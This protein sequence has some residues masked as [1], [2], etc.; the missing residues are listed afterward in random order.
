MD[1]EFLDPTQDN[2]PQDG[3]EAQVEGNDYGDN[4]QDL[5]EEL[6]TALKDL[7]KQFGGEDKSVRRTEVQEAR[8]QRFYWRGDQYIYWNNTS[9]MF[10]PLASEGDSTD[11]PAYQDVYNIY[12][13]FGRGIISVLS[14]NAPGV[15]FEPDDP[16]N[17]ADITTANAAE[18]FR[19]I[20]DR[21][22]K[23]KT[24][25]AEISRL[26]WTDG[27]VVLYTRTVTDAQQFGVDVQGNPKSEEVITA[28][29]V[30]ESKVPCLTKNQTEWPYVILSDEIDINIAK[31]TYKNAADEIKEGSATTGESAYE[32]IARMGVLQG[33]KLLMQAGDAFGHMVTRQRVYLRP[34]AFQKVGNETTRQQLEQLYPE[35]CFIIFCGDAYCESR[36]ESM[37][38]HI[39]V[40]H[41]SPGDG[42]NRSSLGKPMV[43]IQDAFNDLMNE[44]REVYDYCIPVT[45][46]NAE[47]GDI[48]ALREQISEPGNHIPVSA[49]SGLTDLQGAFYTEP[50]ASV[51]GDMVEAINFLGGQL[52]QNITGALPALMGEQME[53]NDTAAAYAQAKNQAMGQLSLAWGSLQEM[54]AA[55]YKQAVVCAASKRSPDQVLFANIPNQKGKVT[56]ES[57]A[58]A[59]LQKGNFHAFPDTESS[60]PDTFE[61]KRATY[62][63]LMAAGDKNQ[64]LQSILTQPDNLEMAQQ[65]IGL[66]DLVIPGADA[67]NKQLKEI[68]MLLQQSPVP[69]SQ[70]ETMQWQQMAQQAQQ[71]GQQPPPQPQP[72]PSIQI[73]AQFDFHEYEYQEVQ[74]WL[75]T[76]EAAMAKKI[77]PQ[78]IQN[79]RLH[80]LA[81]FQQVQ[82]LQQ[83]QQAQQNPPNK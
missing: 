79:V 50:P 47:L 49:P 10:A 32:R 45:W 71:S 74:R 20:V 18:K 34:S 30:L 12:Y 51:S 63:N 81:H 7:V 64:L 17:P 76:E 42:Q 3:M 68:T 41:A 61:S 80:G 70:Q 25:Q 35:G 23:G 77:N 24:L 53:G 28:F 72:Q 6:Q 38:D 26:F 52:P 21:A 57:I 11:A 13:S 75:S 5:P 29:G 36:N 8:R 37:D 65:M 60:F 39:T 58:I 73:D 1:N 66:E 14:Q 2:Q 44:R 15:N 69:P 33:S 22:N 78:G 55:A 9:M 19:H 16:T 67:R 40:G 59:D 46:M 82:K 48:N 31:T 43:P 27:R 4:N 62:M 83:Q 54:Y 56:P